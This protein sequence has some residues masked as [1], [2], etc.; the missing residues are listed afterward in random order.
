[1][2]AKEQ[3]ISCLQEEVKQLILDKEELSDTAQE[4]EKLRTIVK[5]IN[6]RYEE[7]L[8]QEEKYV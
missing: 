2:Q 5:D 6:D 7:H 3:E 4:T 1:M 8:G